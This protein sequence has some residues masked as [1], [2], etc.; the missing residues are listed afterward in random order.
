MDSNS[1]KINNIYIHTYTQKGGN[2]V[3]DIRKEA[4]NYEDGTRT[5]NWVMEEDDRANE[6]RERDTADSV[7][8]MAK[9]GAVKAMETGIELGEKAKQTMDIAWDGFK[10]TTKNVKNA[11][12]GNDDDHGPASL[13][14]TMHDHDNINS[15]VH[16]LRKRA[17]GYDLRDK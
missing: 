15:H 13:S 9:E 8:D 16:N 14:E 3:D 2:W 4:D 6:T 17:G 1:M 12:V 11:V 5:R 10:E 7:A